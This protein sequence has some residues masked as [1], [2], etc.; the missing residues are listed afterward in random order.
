V[1]VLNSYNR[2]INDSRYIE[3]SSNFKKGHE[4]YGRK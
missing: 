1:K 3:V 2:Y 4:N